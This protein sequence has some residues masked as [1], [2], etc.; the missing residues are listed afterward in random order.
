MKEWAVSNQVSSKKCN[1]KHY[2]AC[3]F[4][5]PCSKENCKLKI[6]IW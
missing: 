4:G 6:I 1:K 3:E 2:H 5:G